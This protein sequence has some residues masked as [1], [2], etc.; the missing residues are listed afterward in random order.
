MIESLKIVVQG[1]YKRE[2]MEMAAQKGV[3]SGDLLRAFIVDYVH[4]RY[5][6]R[7]GHIVPTDTYRE[8][9]YAERRN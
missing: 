1:D 2:F 5:R 7:E 3:T 6:Y 9:I 8:H 4:G